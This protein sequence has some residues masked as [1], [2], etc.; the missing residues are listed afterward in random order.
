MGV[1]RIAGLARLAARATEPREVLR[2]VGVAGTGVGVAFAVAPRLGLRVMGLEADGR[3]VSLLA[4]LFASRDLAVGLAMLRASR[5]PRLDAQWLELIAL[6]QVGDLAFSAALRR[7]GHLSRR[8]W[9]IVLLTAGP[10]LVLAS[11][12]RLRAAR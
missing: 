3:G 4:R 2:D 11:A 8:G 5:R 10:T 1:E 7:T 12:A 6:F 9:G